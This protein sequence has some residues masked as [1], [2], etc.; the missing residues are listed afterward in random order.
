M[1]DEV[2]E[3][4]PPLVADESGKEPPVIDLL[5]AACWDAPAEETKTAKMA[6]KK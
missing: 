6:P 5:R 3:E 1:T 4:K 2:K